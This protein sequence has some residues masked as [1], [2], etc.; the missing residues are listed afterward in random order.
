[1]SDTSIVVD[2]GVIDMHGFSE[3][4]MVYCKLVFNSDMSNSM[5]NYRAYNGL[6]YDTFYADLQTLPLYHIT[7]LNDI[8]DKAE[9]LNDCLRYL[10]VICHWKHVKY[11]NIIR[12]G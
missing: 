3:H 4:D 1:M 2:K 10:L 5:V 12:H 11:G 9:F 8:N 6:D 7:E